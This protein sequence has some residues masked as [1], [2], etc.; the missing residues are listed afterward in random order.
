MSNNLDD[1]KFMISNLEKIMIHRFDEIDKKIDT[2]IKCNKDNDDK[3][4]IIKT[5]CQKMGSHIDFIEET[6]VTLQT[7]LNYVKRSVERLIGSS[8]GDLKN[9]PIKDETKK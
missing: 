1:I 7:P 2:L 8:S 3:M 4:N 6:Y 5:E 9:L